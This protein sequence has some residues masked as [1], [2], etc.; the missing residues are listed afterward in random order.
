[1]HEIL[2]SQ[3]GGGPRR[4]SSSAFLAA[5]SEASTP[6]SASRLVIANAPASARTSA[7]TA[8]DA[9][10]PPT[11]EVIALAARAAAHT[12]PGV[13]PGVHHRLRPRRRTVPDDLVHAVRAQHRVVLHHR[14]RHA[15]HHAA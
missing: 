15:S 12:R 11:P 6:G 4:A 7:L 2:G 13:D 3:P 10:M 5:L 8:D 1:M 9:L 14:K